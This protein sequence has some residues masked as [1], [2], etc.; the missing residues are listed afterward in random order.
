MRQLLAIV[1]LMTSAAPAAAQDQQLGARTKAM[2]GSYTA[3]EDDPVSIFLNPAG[4]AT[5]PDQVSVVY[6]TYTVYP[7]KEERGIG[8]AVSTSVEAE[9][10]LSDPAFVPSFF[11][12]VFQLGKPDSPM[13]VG[14]CFARP[15]HLRYSFDEVT[16]VLATSFTPDSDIEQSMNRFR[17]AFAYDFPFRKAGTGGFFTH[18]A[19]GAGL[20]IGFTSWEFSGP[21]RNENDQATSFGFGAGLLVGLYDNT[22]SLKIN[23]GVAYQSAVKYD[24]TINPDILPSFDMPHQLNAGLTVYL[25]PRTPLR[26]TFDFQWIDWSATAEEPSFSVP[27]TRFEDAFNYS[28]GAEYR[29]NLSESVFLYPRMGYRRFDTPW[30]DKNNLPVTGIYK[31]VL[32]TKGD[33]LHLFTFGVGLSWSTDAGKFRRLDLGGDVGG[34]AFNLAIGYTHEF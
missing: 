8:D 15:Y 32:D 10:S 19:L 26:F 1:A 5:Q 31:L 14:V 16:D 25:L 12:A 33:V 4:I 2:G 13:A 6:Q 30:E 34:D 18:L 28:V 20:D 21:T 27:M 3:F 24:F 23:L 22:E 11:G 17:T 9:T 7:V 29:I